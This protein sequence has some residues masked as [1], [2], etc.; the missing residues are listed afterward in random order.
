MPRRPARDMSA[1]GVTIHPFD[2]GS[3][4]PGDGG[5]PLQG[6]LHLMNRFTADV[7]DPA[8]PYLVT[9]TLRARDG[10]LAP[11][12]MLIA[13]LPDGPPITGYGLRS[14]IIDA[15]IRRIR[16][17]L[18]M[19]GGGPVIG[20]SRLHGR[21]IPASAVRRSAGK[22]TT[23]QAAD[24]Y[25][26]ALAN[27]ATMRRATAAVGEAL[28]TSRGYASRLL[29]QARKEGLLGPAA[30]GQAGEVASAAHAAT[31]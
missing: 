26:D 31:M 25:R 23:Q 11:E 7:R 27:P 18:E 30:K 8:L 24:A 20:G 29:S 1:V 19:L 4:R 15:Y 10:R 12:T 13:E 6:G 21:A 3:G 16:Q 2:L 22:V 5:G 14:V 28:N 17:E 9:L